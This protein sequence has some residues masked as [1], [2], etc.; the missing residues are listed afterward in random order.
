[1][2]FAKFITALFAL[3]FLGCQISTTSSVPSAKPPSFAG[4]W[5]L[6]SRIDKD[7]K[8][9]LV[10]EPTL[11]S[12]PI[13]ILMYDTLGNMSVQIMKRDRN[14]S[15]LTT[16]DQTLNNS[17]AFN[18]YDAY[19][20]TYQVDTAKKQ[21]THIISGSIDPKDVGKHL[22][23]N[24]LFIHDTLSLSFSTTNAGIPVTRTVTFIREKN[25]R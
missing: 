18:G 8:N 1:M 4:T 3:I 20:G 21:V 9:I 10:N 23:R 13:A 14:N 25:S 6:V 17:S 12:D 11:G 16:E 2:S 22:T 24:Y 19:F 5:K 7:A 15:I